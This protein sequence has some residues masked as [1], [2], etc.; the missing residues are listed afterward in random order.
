CDTANNGKEAISSTQIKN[1]DVILLDVQ[2]PD[3][4]GFEVAKAIRTNST[5]RNQNTPIIIFSASTDIRE[6]KIKECQA[7]DFIGKPFRPEELIE[8]MQKVLTLKN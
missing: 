1:Y 4:N 8:K 5:S 3:M 7:N 2:M 6:D